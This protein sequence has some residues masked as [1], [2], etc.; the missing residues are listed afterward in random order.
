MRTSLLFLLLTIGLP[1]MA[2]AQT[3]PPTT[4][5]SSEESNP[6]SAPAAPP[7]APPKYTIS[8]F[9]ENY[10]YLKDPSNET[11]CL[12]TIKY[13][14]LNAAGDWYASFGGQ[15]R[16]RYE[17]FNHN[18]FGTGPQTR[19][20][21]NLARI[22]ENVDLHFG[23]DLRVFVQ[24]ASALEAGRNGG[25]R[26][27]DRDELDLEQGFADY[28][29]PLC[30]ESDLTLRGGRQ[31]LQY[32]AERLIG[33]A[34][35]LNARHNFDGFRANLDCEDDSLDFFLVR[36]CRSSFINLTATTTKMPSPDSTTRC[37]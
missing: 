21:Y 36:P 27:T 17:F 24:G 10:E 3:A 34:D 22:T 28:T 23:P 13:V 9:E 15:I 18:T 35:F 6:S 16:D 12:D 26:P 4:L 37:N 30:S 14:P 5:P 25:P 11:D 33:P 19:D 31:Y 20:G 8:R 1:G 29:I 32:G 7:V 2:A